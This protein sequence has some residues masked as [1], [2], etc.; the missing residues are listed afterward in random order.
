MSKREMSEEA[1]GET[2]S[3]IKSGFI[4]ADLQKAS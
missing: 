2:P 4:S 1:K 3:A